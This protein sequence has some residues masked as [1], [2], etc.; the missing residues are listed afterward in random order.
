[1]KLDNQKEPNAK[2]KHLWAFVATFSE[3]PHKI[4]RYSQM[5]ICP[6]KWMIYNRSPAFKDIFHDVFGMSEQVE[7]PH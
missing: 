5:H 2:L 3:M 7:V 4:L 6:I 1:M